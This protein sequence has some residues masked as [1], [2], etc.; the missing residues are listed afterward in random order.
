MDF[1]RAR[2]FMVRYRTSLKDF[3]ILIA[4]FLVGLYLT[5][6]YDIFKNSDG[7]AMH[8]RT[9]ELDETLLLGGIMALGLLAFS[10]W[11]YIEQRRETALRVT[12]EQHVRTL[13]F[14]DALTGLANRRQFDDALKAATEAPPREGAVHALILLDLNGFKQVNDIAMALAIKCS[15]SSHN[16]WPE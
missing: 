10:V 3:S 13:A 8:E 12:A 5:F 16:A 14:Q 9:V 4:V 1:V 6:E 7:V 11:R 2:S 15:P